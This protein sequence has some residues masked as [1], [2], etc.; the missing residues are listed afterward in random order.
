MSIPNQT[1]TQ[2]A[3]T[4][5]CKNCGN[6]ITVK[7][8]IRT[9]TGYICRECSR[10]QQRVF[11]TA[12]WFD[13]IV[14]MVVAGG[15]SFLGSLLFGF[16]SGFLGFYTIFLLLVIGPAAGGIIA[17]AVRAAVQKRRGKNL[18]L[19]TAAATAIG[20]ALPV[21]TRFI[22]GQYSLFSLIF[23]AAFVVLVTS[24]VYYRLS[25]I[26]LRR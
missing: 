22:T 16:I 25:G 24:A 20:S 23:S 11:V 7:E 12:K 4:L 13:Y 26:Q 15:L 9:P 2:D 19:T 21:L 8:A 6:P 5:R 3:P 1:E 18:F 14:A 17:E 10:S